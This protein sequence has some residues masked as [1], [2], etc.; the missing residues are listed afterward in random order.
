VKLQRPTQTFLPFSI[1]SIVYLLLLAFLPTNTAT[2]E[3]Y[4]LSSPEY[5]ILGLLLGI[6]RIIVWFA[7][8]YG[9]WRLDQYTMAIRKTVDGRAFMHVS[10][11]LRWLAWGLPLSGIV[12]NLTGGITHAHPGFDTAGVLITHFITLIISLVSF[13]F[14]STGSRELLDSTGKQMPMSGL[15][16]FA[17]GFIFIG[18]A[19]CYA[20]VRGVIVQHGH[21]YHMPMWLILLTVVIPYL[22][23]WLMG[24]LAAYDFSLYRKHS[25]GLLYKSALNKLAG[26]LGL[27]IITS[28]LL[29]YITSTL[30]Y[31]R[32]ITLDWRLVGVYIILLV[33]A[34]GFILLARGA[35]QLKMI[36]EV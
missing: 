35:N 22:Y 9:F 7:A 33:Y 10:R 24:F 30:T 27:I 36:E 16:V 3:S 20:T 12:G 23:A 31:L 32:R 13:S 26:G 15:R 1:L 21:P 17:L 34:T 29:Q 19:Y 28:V 14:I 25:S 11:G 6:P 5:H 18:V 2:A 4:H 8:F